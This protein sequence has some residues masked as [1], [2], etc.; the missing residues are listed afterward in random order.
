MNVLI[1]RVGFDHDSSMWDDMKEVRR[2]WKKHFTDKPET[3][4]FVQLVEKK[5]E[6]SVGI[7]SYI[8]FKSIT[9]LYEFVADVGKPCYLSVEGRQHILTIGS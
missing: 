6:P 5:E 7:D 2:K 3:F 9:E 8:V 4:G 1:K